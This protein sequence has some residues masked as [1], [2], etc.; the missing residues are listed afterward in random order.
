MFLGFCLVLGPLVVVA[1][2]V[3]FIGSILSAGTMLVSLI[4]TA[5]VAPVVIAIAWFFYRPLVSVVV[6]AVGFAAAYGF[7]KL[8]PRR[9]AAAVPVPPA[10]AQ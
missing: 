7:R 5:V 8:A 2:V 3:P 6:L 10:P 4:A 9:K 1:D